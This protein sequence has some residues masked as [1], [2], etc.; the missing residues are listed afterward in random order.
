MKRTVSSLL[1]GVF[2]FLLGVGFTLVCR[3]PVVQPIK[4]APV[5]FPEQP[6]ITDQPI[7]AFCELAKNPNKYSGQVVRISATLSRFIHGGVLDDPICSS[8]ETRT[9]VFYRAENRDEIETV[10]QEARHSE[11]WTIPVSIIALGEFRKVNP[12]Y[13]SDAIYDTALLQFEII[14][15]ETASKQATASFADDGDVCDHVARIKL[16]P[17]EGNAGVDADYDALKAAGETAV[18]CLIRMITDTRPK[19]DPRS[20]PRWGDVRTTVGDTAVFMLQE[21]AG[22]EIIKLLPLKYQR[23]YKQIGV[24]AEEEYLHDGPNHRRILQ[25]KLSNWYSTTYLPSLRNSN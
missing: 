10:L 9:A 14:C 17:F 20:I 3:Y 5:A 21:I 18:P 13:E 22:F 15:I 12:S 11:D 24:Y 6:A 25:R 2:T 23:L 4:S 1:L 19:P 8:V 7:L 16:I